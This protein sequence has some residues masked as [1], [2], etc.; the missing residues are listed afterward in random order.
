MVIEVRA[1][2]IFSLNPYEISE[3]DKF[4]QKK[5]QSKMQE[6]VDFLKKKVAGVILKEQSRSYQ[7]PSR[8][9][10]GSLHWVSKPG[11]PPNEDTGNLR[12]GLWSGAHIGPYRGSSEVLASLGINAFDPDTRE[13]YSARLEYGIG[14]LRRPYFYDTIVKN[15]RDPKMQKYYDQIRYTVINELEG[16]AMMSYPGLGKKVS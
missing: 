14:V 7:V 11:F 3:L 13:E 12:R 16:K 1:K 4:V 8:K 5:I 9:K 2:R 15:V 6:G 10:D